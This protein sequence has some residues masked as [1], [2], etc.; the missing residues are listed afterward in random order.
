MK[1]ICGFCGKEHRVKKPKE[2][3]AKELVLNILVDVF[4]GEVWK[5]LAYIEADGSRVFKEHVKRVK[6]EIN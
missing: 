4:G 2:C 3:K 1:K 6:K 5:A